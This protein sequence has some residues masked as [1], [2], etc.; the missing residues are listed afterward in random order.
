MVAV[1]PDRLALQVVVRVRP[2]N[3]RE[4]AAG[5]AL[6]VQLSDVDTTTLQVRAPDAD[7]GAHL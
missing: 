7:A 3:D 6:A 2:M 1:P 4:T 5:E